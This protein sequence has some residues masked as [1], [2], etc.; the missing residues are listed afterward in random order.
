MV[1]FINS[2]NPKAKL[3]TSA[4]LRNYCPTK[5]KLTVNKEAAKDFV[6]EEYHD[7][8]LD[9]IKFNPK[10]SGI[11]KNKLMVLDILAN[12]TGNALY[13]LQ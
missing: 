12:L 1:D 5:V 6:P 4:G 13:T 2:N 8:I 3:R 9:E 11:F 10:G 7:Q